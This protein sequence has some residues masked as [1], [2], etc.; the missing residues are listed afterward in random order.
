MDRFIGI[1]EASL[2]LGVCVQTLRRWDES[3]RLRCMD[4]DHIKIKI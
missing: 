1:G 4:L 2:L 3:G